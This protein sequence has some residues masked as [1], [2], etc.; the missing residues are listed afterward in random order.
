M[1]SKN[2]Q[3]LQQAFRTGHWKSVLVNR[4]TQISPSCRFWQDAYLECEHLCA[5]KL[6]NF[7]NIRA[8]WKVIVLLQMDEMPACA[9][10]IRTLDSTQQR[11]TVKWN[12]RLSAGDRVGY[13]FPARK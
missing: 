10:A 1:A 13:Y 8:Y 9:R 7:N 4:S 3:Q 2:L 6:N 11:E 5:D 12:L